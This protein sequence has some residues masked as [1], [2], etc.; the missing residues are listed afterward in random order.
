M[1]FEPLLAFLQPHLPPFAFHL[2]VNLAGSA[3][4]VINTIAFAL[5]NPTDPEAVDALKSLVPSLLSVLA[6]YF[7]VMSVY[8]TIRSAFRLVFFIV[9]WVGI[10]GALGMGF[11]YLT[12]GGNGGEFAD[13]AARFDK[14]ET[15]A[16]NYATKPTE[17]KTGSRS[18]WDKFD[19]RE[20]NE[21]GGGKLW[22]QKDK[23]APPN[24]KASAMNFVLEQV[25]NYKWAVDALLDTTNENVAPKNKDKSKTKP[26]AASK[27]KAGQRV[28]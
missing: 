10:I 20:R 25:G 4:S 16:K 18:V 17:G 11:A 27:N 1:D 12:N 5:T 13:L 26:R 7:T 28:R 22:W 3:S 9:K 8:R 19:A 2:V 14:F 15:A 21:G 6:L 23:D 24:M